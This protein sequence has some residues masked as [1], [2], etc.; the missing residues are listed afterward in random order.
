MITKIFRGSSAQEVMKSIKDTMGEGAVILSTRQLPSKRVNG[1]PSIEIIA[2]N[3]EQVTSRKTSYSNIQ[4]SDSP[5]QGV[6]L[7]NDGVNAVSKL[8]RILALN[9][10]AEDLIEQI[11]F[12]YVNFDSDGRHVNPEYFAL[13]IGKMVTCNAA[14][15]ENRIL[16]L[17]GP[18]GVGKTTTIC[19][20]ALREE[21]AGKK[22]G[23]I[24]LDSQSSPS[25]RIF[26]TLGDIPVLPATSAREFQ[27]GL[28]KLGDLDCILVD[29]PGVGPADEDLIRVL[30]RVFDDAPVDKLLLFPASGNIYDLQL[31]A[32]SFLPL[33][34]G[35]IGISKIDETTYFGPCFSTIANLHLPVEYFAT[36]KR[37]PEDLEQGNV[38]R[39]TELLTRAV[40]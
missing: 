18:T 2:M 19:K 27:I 32:K 9:G 10:V 29:T 33:R 39:L 36:G 23:V 11:A 28:E 16:A 4:S 38:E 31:M 6:S 25:G 7:S 15:L 21:R 30:S 34:V 26:E 20:L 8:L 40:H 35:S 5:E 37:I 17:V 1:N 3:G 24:S 14:S 12:N 22:V 13:A